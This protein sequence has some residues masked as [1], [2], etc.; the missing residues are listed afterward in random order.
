MQPSK[1]VLTSR[2]V[3]PE[4]F[5]TNTPAYHTC[6]KVLKGCREVGE[7][8]TL[9]ELVKSRR[10]ISLLLKVS[11]CWAPDTAACCVGVGY[12]RHLAWRK[13]TEKMIRTEIAS[14]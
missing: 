4:A 7:Q 9:G 5:K 1:W 11:L 10:Q 2:E 3:C 12:S 8:H 14:A 13:A 6:D